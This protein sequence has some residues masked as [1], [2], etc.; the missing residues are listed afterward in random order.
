MCGSACY[1]LSTKDRCSR[2]REHLRD[3]GRD[4]QAISETALIQQKGNEEKQ[5]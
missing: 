2:D 5:K 3:L 4:D 1:E